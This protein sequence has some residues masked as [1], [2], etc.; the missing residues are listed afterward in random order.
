MASFS[1]WLHSKMVVKDDELPVCV[2]EED[3]VY[4]AILLYAKTHNLVPHD[5]SNWKIS[6]RARGHM[7]KAKIFA[8]GKPNY[9]AIE[10]Y[11]TRGAK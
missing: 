11:P 8:T 10:L 9:N 6:L 1:K 3:D 2:L 4:R 7:V 5:E